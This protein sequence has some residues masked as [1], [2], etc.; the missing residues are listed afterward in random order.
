M[1]ASLIDPR[2]V[3]LLDGRFKC[4]SCDAWH[5]G[6]FDLACNRPDPCPRSIPVAEEEPSDENNFLTSDLC[7]LGGKTFFVR[8]I[9]ELPLRDGPA[10]QR[11]AFGVWTSLSGKSF[12]S[13]LEDDGDA[14]RAGEGWFGWLANTLKG[15]PGEPTLGCD[16]FPQ[17][18][19]MRPKLVLHDAEHPLVRD[20]REGIS[21]DRLLEIYAA[22]GHDIAAASFGK[23]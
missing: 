8:A 10:D 4:S 13:Y 21:F 6:L 12:R 18:G 23:H 9:L 1:S 3:R 7:V 15:Y 5:P 11:F 19:N 16:V 17:D 20:Q 14:F 22:N 2:W